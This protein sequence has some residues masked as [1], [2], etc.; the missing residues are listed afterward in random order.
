MAA[1]QPAVTT[2]FLTV[3]CSS[4]SCSASLSSSTYM[5]SEQL[6]TLPGI[7]PNMTSVSKCMSYP[8]IKRNGRSLVNSC[9]LEQRHFWKGNIQSLLLTD[10][11]GCPWLFHSHEIDSSFKRE[12]SKLWPWSVWILSGTPNW[13]MNSSTSFWATEN[14]SWFGRG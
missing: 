13:Q 9:T 5:Y 8:S 1:Q 10:V 12:D 3:L 7:R 6:S 2:L 14:T 4:T 11:F